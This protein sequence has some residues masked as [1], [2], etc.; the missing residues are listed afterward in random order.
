MKRYAIVRVDN[1][2]PTRFECRDFEGHIN[3]YVCDDRKDNKKQPNCNKCLYG[4]TKEQ[5]I[6]KVKQAI[7]IKLCK[8][9]FNT[10]N[11]QLAKFIIEFL[12]VEE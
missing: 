7:D 8:D 11:Q 3:Y 2:C 4:D 1:V 10:T 12:G 6:A 5:L 9:N